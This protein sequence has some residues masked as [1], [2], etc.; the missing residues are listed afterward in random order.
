MLHKIHCCHKQVYANSYQSLSDHGPKYIDC[1]MSCTSRAKSLQNMVTYF[2]CKIPEKTY[3][4][5]CFA[6]K[7]KDR[8]KEQRVIL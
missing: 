8:N 2:C 6:K 3:F 5:C 7:V 1:F 4:C